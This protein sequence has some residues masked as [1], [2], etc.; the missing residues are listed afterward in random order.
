M[1]PVVIL[2]QNHTFWK[3]TVLLRFNFSLDSYYSQYSKKVRWIET[4]PYV[5]Q[6]IIYF[7]AGVILNLFYQRWVYLDWT[8]LLLS[9]SV[10]V[11]CSSVVIRCFRDEV[12]CAHF[13]LF[14]TD[15]KLTFFKAI[16][17]FVVLVLTRTTL[18]VFLLHFVN[19]IDFV[20]FW[21]WENLSLL[22]FYPLCN[23]IERSF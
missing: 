6:N 10:M 20:Y 16:S 2:K 15:K 12:E 4:G 18:S 23:L 7:L 8:Y 5:S 1:R 22:A 21:Y 9:G 19:N 3:L 17:F 14:I 11:L 13:P